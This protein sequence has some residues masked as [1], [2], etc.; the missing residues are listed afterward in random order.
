[1][2][3]MTSRVALAFASVCAGIGVLCSSHADSLGVKVPPDEAILS[4]FGKHRDEFERLRQMVTEDKHT[5]RMSVFNESTIASLTPETG[6]NAYR[7]LLQLSPGM[8]VG[9]NYDDSVRFV[10][11]SNGQ[12]VGSGWAKGLEFVPTGA[13]MI[14]TKLANLDGSSK[15]LPGVYLRQIDP[16][17]FLFYQQ[18]D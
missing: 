7:N 2:R 17:W 16:R 3:K 12:A 9:V 11:A 18:D 13:K 8:T 1:M 5:F 15:I 4:L 10:F 6:R 14:G